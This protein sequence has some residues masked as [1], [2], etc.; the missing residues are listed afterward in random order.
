MEKILLTLCILSSLAAEAGGFRVALQGAKQLAMAHTSAHAEDASVAF[1]NPAG[2][3]FI[4][5]KLSIV[6][7]GFA[8]NSSIAYQNPSTRESYKT[9]SPLGTPFY[10]AITYK[11]T[12]DLSLGFSV[13]TPYGSTVQWPEN[14]AGKELVQKMQLKSFYF[15]P[16]ISVKLASWMSVGVSYIYARGSVSWDRSVTLLNGNLNI[17]ESSAKGSGFG[18]GFY[19]VPNEKLN[20]S[21]TYRS[22]VDMEA[23]KGTATFTVS[24]SLFPVLGLSASGRDAF[25]ATLPLAEEYT[26]GFAYKVSSKLKIAADF[27]YTGWERYSKL[28][29]YFKNAPIGNQTDP[30]ILSVPKNFRNTKTF[31]V[32]GEYR[33][34]PLISGRLGWYWDESP[35]N[36]DNFTPETPSFNTHVITAG[37][38]LNFRLFGIDLATAQA[39][40]NGRSFYNKNNGFSGKAKANA[41]YFGLGI[42]YNLKRKNEKITD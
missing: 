33:F 38:G 25:R 17:K 15:Q 23:N 26:I 28:D 6:A 19:F 8:V 18:L 27:N 32:G 10:T 37:M 2:I 20:V 11:A 22:P 35:Y 16:V 9:N 24:P 29:L 40:P 3:S 13:T 5:E 31:R 4:P 7:G 39:F 21:V 12:E 42:R 36:D 41:F 34:S 30:R 1:F 14:W